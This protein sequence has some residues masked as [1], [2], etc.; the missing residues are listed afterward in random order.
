MRTGGLELYQIVFSD[1][2]LKT[3]LAAATDLI[4]QDRPVLMS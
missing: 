1:E 4:S 3:Y 2:Q